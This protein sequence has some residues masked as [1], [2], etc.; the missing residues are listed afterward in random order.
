MSKHNWTYEENEI[1]CRRY[2][3]HYVLQ[4]SNLSISEFV[5]LLKVELPHLKETSLRRKASNIKQ[6]S[7]EAKLADSSN[8]APSGNYSADNKQAFQKLLREYELIKK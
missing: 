2:L 8:C 6:L 7:I 1:C 4:S 5:R 3:E